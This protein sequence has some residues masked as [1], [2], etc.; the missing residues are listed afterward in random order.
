MG[1]ANGSRIC[2]PDD[3]LRDTHQLHLMEMMGFAGSSHPAYW[4]VAGITGTDQR[5]ATLSSKSASSVKTWTSGTDGAPMTTIQ[6]VVF[7]VMLALT[8]SLVLLAFLLW[9]EGIGLRSNSE[10]DGR[11]PYP[12]PQ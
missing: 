11:P 12:K 2:A 5:T 4:W 7:G 8:P 6:A 9:R 3:K 1:G 10:F